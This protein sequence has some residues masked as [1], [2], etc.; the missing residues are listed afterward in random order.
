MSEVPIFAWF[1]IFLFDNCL[2]GLFT[3]Y[4]L[5]YSILWLAI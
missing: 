4:S 1:C 3:V 5:F 2:P